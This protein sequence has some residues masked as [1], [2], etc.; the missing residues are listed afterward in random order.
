MQRAIQ[1]RVFRPGYTSPDRSNVQRAIMVSISTIAAVCTRKGLAGTVSKV[2]AFVTRFT[3]IGR[4]DNHH[5]NTIQ[6]RFVRNKLAQLVKRPR[7]VF[8][9]LFLAEP[10]YGSIPYAFQVLQRNATTRR[11][12]FL[13]QSFTNRV[14]N[15]GR[16]RSL[17]FTDSFRSCLS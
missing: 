9:A 10:W 14:V 17:S 15:D 7:T 4:W 12:G 13:N 3:G 1:S 8:I 11:L 6:L 16:G 2:M 5:R